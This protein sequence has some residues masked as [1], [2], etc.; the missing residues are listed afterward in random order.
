LLNPPERQ[1][2]RSDRLQK[3]RHCFFIGVL[4]CV[5]G[6]QGFPLDNQEAL[7]LLDSSDPANRRTGCDTLSEAQPRASL[8]PQLAFLIENHPDADTR[9]C[10][11]QTISQKFLPNEQPVDAFVHSL[12]DPEERVQLAAASAIAKLESVPAIALPGLLAGFRREH[13]YSMKMDGQAVMPGY[14]IYERALLRAGTPEARQAV[15]ESKRIRSER[16]A[17]TNEDYRKKQE[18]LRYDP[19]D[20]RKEETVLYR[21]L[22][23]IALLIPLVLFVTFI[24]RR[25]RRH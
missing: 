19:T 14:E 11:V 3:S 2:P 7:R 5:F 25:M 4:L 12:N 6:A 18:Q 9:A 24:I 23:R 8:L 13:E 16:A 20:I 1:S 17:R 15:D 22:G 21:K 10:V